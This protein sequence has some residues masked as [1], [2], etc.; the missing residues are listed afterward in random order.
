MTS[1]RFVDTVRIRVKGGRGGD[2]A[3]SF[4]HEK[5]R[6]FGGPDG[7]DGGKGGD[8]I[9]R[10][11]RG[12][13][14]LLDFSYRSHL[15]ASDGGNG[16]GTNKSGAD[17]EDLVV[18]VP[19][20]TVVHRDGKLLADLAMPGERV[21]VARGGRGGRGNLSFKS[22][23]NTAPRLYERGEPGETG[24]LELELKLIADV[25]LVGFPNAGKST[26]LARVSN[27]RPK[28]ADYPFTTLAPHLGLVRHKA[29]SFVMAD[30]PGLI[31]G[32]HEGKGLGIRFLRHIERTRLLIH[33]VDPLG[34]GGV[35]P[36]DGVSK[37]EEELRR[38][39]RVLGAKPRLLA[40][41]KADLP[42]SAEALRRVRA[43]LR[44]RKVFL[45]SAATGE[46]VTELLDAAI[47]EL[48]RTPREVVRF[49]PPAGTTEV[50]MA[51]GFRV[52]RI[53]TASFRVSGTYVERVA[54]MTDI[55][56]LESLYR[57]QYALRKIGVDRALRAAGVQEGDIVAIGEME[58]E[59]S[60]APLKAPPKLSP[61]YRRKE[62]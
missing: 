20:G 18:R 7:G 14:T 52:D 31:E 22:R 32:A 4:L 38:Y 37:I 29:V 50:R 15:Y 48:G 2:G 21:C 30:I 16:K 61:S 56:F 19:A 45:F 49:E 53:G 34:F 17:A 51:R 12:I 25:G 55:H 26:L 27:A 39:S 10:A 58:L 33:L 24:D 8:V 59:W 1:F 54:S 62:R 41:N 35:R 23:H 11:D 60:D 5:Y 43:R 13:G 44:K 40:V 57:L 36:A 9:L 6:E 47:S 42:E 46:G 28:I 3:L